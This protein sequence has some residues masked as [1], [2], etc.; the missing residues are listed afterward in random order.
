MAI[1]LIEL[2]KLNRNREVSPALNNFDPNINAIE[3]IFSGKNF[4]YLYNN[5]EAFLLIFNEINNKTY[6]KILFQRW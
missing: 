3:L 6:E 4:K 5:D 1:I 2:Q